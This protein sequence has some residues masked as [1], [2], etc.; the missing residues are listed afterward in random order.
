MNK[1]KIDWGSLGGVQ[2]L[3]LYLL[4]IISLVHELC[5]AIFYSTSH[6]YGF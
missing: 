1:F 4:I 5:H 6:R 2:Q 3:K